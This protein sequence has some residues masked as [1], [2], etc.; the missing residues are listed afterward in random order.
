M[1]ES[2]K[3]EE[4][5][6]FERV[7]ASTADQ[8]KQIATFSLDPVANLLTTF[9]MQ[10]TP[11]VITIAE[12]AKEVAAELLAALPF[13]KS[14]PFLQELQQ[15]AGELARNFQQLSTVPPQGTSKTP[16]Q[17]YNDT[18]KAL[19]DNWLDNTIRVPSND[20]RQNV[21]A[22]LR[23]SLAYLHAERI[24]VQKIPQ[25]SAEVSALVVKAR[26][27]GS[28]IESIL[29]KIKDGPQ[30]QN[31]DKFASHFRTAAIEHGKAAVRASVAA[32]VL[33]IAACVFG[34]CAMSSGPSAAP[35][36]ASASSL[37]SC[38]TGDVSLS[39]SPVATT[40]AWLGIRLFILSLLTTG[41]V[42]LLRL[43]RTHKHLEVLNMHRANVLSTY[44]LVIGDAPSDI[45]SM[46][47]QQA[48]ATIFNAGS[49]GFLGDQEFRVDQE[50]MEIMREAVLRKAS[51][52]AP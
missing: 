27:E 36:P 22:I 32:I 24:G 8:L 45:R 14:Q 35:T 5:S 29:A 49:T 43:F 19:R 42:V 34:Y 7:R 6:E 9:K 38:A 2:G 26:S 51:N 21:S 33:G 12:D 28:E 20:R 44:Q 41:F 48:A 11:D 25:H 18:T 47:L 10:V 37:P 40:V 23:A 4:L 13:A 16:E 3:Q 31:L 50:A 30:R 39:A 46:L 17:H 1:A 52:P 15:A